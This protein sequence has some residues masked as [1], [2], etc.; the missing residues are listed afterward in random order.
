[1][2]RILKQA[3]EERGQ[4][5]KT[6][7][8][9]LSEA[10][11]ARRDLTN[12]E[13][14]KLDTLKGEIFSRD[15]IIAAEQ[16]E[17][18]NHVASNRYSQGELATMSGFS[19]QRA[20]RLLADG[21]PLDGLEGEMHAEGRSYAQNSGI[22]CSGNLVLPD[23]ILAERRDMTATGQT[24]AAGDQGGD[25]FGTTVTK[26]LSPL[27]ARSVLRKLGARLLTGLSGNLAIP[28]MGTSVI[29]H[30]P[31]TGT[32]AESSP[33]TS[34]ITLAPNRIGSYVEISKQ[35][36]IQTDSEVERLVRG[37][38]LENLALMI[39]NGAI[40]GTGADNQPMGLLHASSGID[41][42]VVGG[43]HGGAPTWDHVVDL[44]TAIATN[45]AD[46][47]NLGYLGN[48]KVRGKLKKT[49]KH[50]AGESYVWPESNIVN[51]RIAEVTTQ[52]PS[53]LTKGDSTGICSALIFGNWDD[54]VV[55]MWGGLDITVNPYVK[56]I[57]G[58]VR[59]TAQGFYDTAIR[60]G[61]SFAAMKDALTA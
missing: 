14:R 5:L 30:H 38:L 37:D 10:R 9:I 31:E 57:D 17:I 1:M 49:L 52:V 59:V 23:A 53:N 40:N 32:L 8:E 44:E 56:D 26:P 61:E 60:R 22:V 16:A 55:A 42:S 36:I 20:I 39:E 33:G 58:L 34:Q 13:A 51:G 29:G 15:R 7:D 46:I 6:A 48:P 41:F 54:L 19:F 43:T 35:L 25:L 18:R 3:T 27:Y 4:L 21:K 11:S 12:E 28:K 24:S 45:N 47:N 50:A 2:S